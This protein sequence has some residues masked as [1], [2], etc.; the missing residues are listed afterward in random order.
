MSGFV[1]EIH[2][3]PDALHRVLDHFSAE[4]LYPWAKKLKDGTLKRVVFTGMG[5]SYHAAA[6]AVI[7]L[8]EHGIPASAVEASELV[9]Y[10]KLDAQT[11]LI[12]I[13]QSGKSV[14]V[15]RLI[16]T[17]NKSSTNIPIIGITND[18]ESPL[19][20]HSDAVILLHAGAELTVSSKTYTNT[21][22][23]LDLLARTLRSAPT[24]PALENL[25]LLADRMAEALPD[26]SKQ[27]ETIA[28]QLAISHFLVFL[29]RGPSR[30]SAMTGALIMKESTKLPTEG[31]VSGQFRHGPIEV[32]SRE[33]VTFIFAS[34]GRAAALNL[35]LARDLTQLSGQVFVIG[36]DQVVPG[37]VRITT[38]QHPA[39]DEWIAP[40]IEMIPI[41]LIAAQLAKQRGFDTSRFMHGS[42]V[43]TRE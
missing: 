1:A 17:I 23:V 3:Q 13:S 27:A 26:W 9:Y 21:L 20:L 28:E 16:E 4:A 43:T 25:R 6:P 11:L 7:M 8:E 38:P 5:S 40:L 18:A 14:E 31:M 35:G 42:K 36:N 34:P 30:T 29:G 2:E 37:A 33:M 12:A 15:V 41:Q 19:A 10:G 24:Q 32:V 39:I 22:A